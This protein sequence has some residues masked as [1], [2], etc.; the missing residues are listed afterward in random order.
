VACAAHRQVEMMAAFH[1]KLCEGAMRPAAYALMGQVRAHT[2]AGAFRWLA[3]DSEDFSRIRH[4]YQ[5]LPAGVL[6][7]TLVSASWAWS[8]FLATT[9]CA[10]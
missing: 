2:E 5:K 8:F 1:R 7:T 9:F 4:V 10:C 3:Q 6:R